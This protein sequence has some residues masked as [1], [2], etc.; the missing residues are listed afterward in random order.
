MA[1]L[2]TAI[3]VGVGLVYV[4]LQ[5]RGQSQRLTESA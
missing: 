2:L 3:V 4:R 5:R 1:V